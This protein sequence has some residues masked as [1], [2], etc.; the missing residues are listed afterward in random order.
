[1]KL[2]AQMLPVVS[3]RL[4][5]V[6]FD[7]GMYSERHA[8]LLGLGEERIVIGMRM[9]LARHHEW[10]DPAA[11]APVF[12]GTF[13]LAGGRL[14]LAVRQMRDR[15]QP[16]AAVLAEVHNPPV[17]GAGKSLSEFDVLAFG[18]IEEAKSRIKECG[19]E[20]LLLDS[21]QA[22]PG[23]HRAKRRMRS[24]TVKIL[25][26]LVAHG[27]HAAQPGKARAIENLGELA[28]DFQVL[29]ATVVCAD[30]D[31]CA[32]VP[33]LEVG[34]PQGRVFEHVS[35]G[36]DGAPVFESVNLF[37][38]SNHGRYLAPR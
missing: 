23:I 28:G 7:S 11:L 34:V 18:F 25:P 37:L 27:T 14:G 8:K 1:I 9:W 38:P 12:G 5:P 3:A 2:P 29:F 4:S 21:G 15:N 22:L 6:R 36:I 35:V 31:R 10:R 20:T 17:V 16:A 33:A 19:F 26:R 24:I 30:S 13:G 32:L